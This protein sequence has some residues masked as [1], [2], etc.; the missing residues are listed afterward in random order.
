MQ[1][2]C[3]ILLKAIY[4]WTS[5]WIIHCIWD[6]AENIECFCGIEERKMMGNVCDQS[7]QSNRR[8][9]TSDWLC[10]PGSRS[11]SLPPLSPKMSRSARAS[12]PRFL[13]SFL[14]SKVQSCNRFTTR[15]GLLCIIQSAGLIWAEKALAKR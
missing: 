4:L 5:K 12:S 2:T 9:L 13:P 3:S 7:K 1:Y 6:Q 11:L 8:V 15:G 10:L 14:Q